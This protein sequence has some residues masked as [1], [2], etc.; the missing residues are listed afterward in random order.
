MRSYTLMIDKNIM[1]GSSTSLLWCYYAGAKELLA[2]QSYVTVYGNTAIEC[3]LWHC[4]SMEAMVNTLWIFVNKKR[5]S[6]KNRIT[7]L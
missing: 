1:F 4:L 2:S 7:N 6:T 5:L 3:C